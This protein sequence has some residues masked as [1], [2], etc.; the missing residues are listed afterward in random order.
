MKLLGRRDDRIE[1][2]GYSFFPAEVE[3]EL[4]PVDGAEQYLIAGVPD[5][6]G[7]LGE[8]PWAFVVAGEPASFSPGAFRRQAR[9]MLPA[10]M[11]PRKVVVIPRLPLTASGK[12]D[13]RSAVE[14][15]A[16]SRDG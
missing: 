16:V 11:V 6:R 7:V 5:P 1:S 12:P 15:Y 8:I 10:Y 4:G 3:A 9:R 13:R 14:T 2:A